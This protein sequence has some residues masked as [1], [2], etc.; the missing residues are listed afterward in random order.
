VYSSFGNAD[1]D[2]S[3]PGSDALMADQERYLDLD[4]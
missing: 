1:V 2:Y 3:G 4:R